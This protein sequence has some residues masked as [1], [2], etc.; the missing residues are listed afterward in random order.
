MIGTKIYGKTGGDRRDETDTAGKLI[1]LCKVPA[2]IRIKENEESNKA[3]KQAIDMPGVTTTKLP[4]TDYY[5]TMWRAR[6]S[7][8]QGEWE[9]NTTRYTT[10]N[11][12]SK[13]GKVPTT[14]VSNTRSNWVGYVL[15]T[16]E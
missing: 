6:N 5:L 3:A 11:H 4:H 8:W 9:K 15:D 12:P 14:A 13:N 2:H 7:E 16:L 10:L 1:T